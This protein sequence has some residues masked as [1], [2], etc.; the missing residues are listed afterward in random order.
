MVTEILADGEIALLADGG[1]L[2]RAPRARGHAG[3]D[4][5]LPCPTRRNGAGSAEDCDRLCRLP[6]GSGGWT[7]TAAKRSPLGARPRSDDALVQATGAL[8]QD[9]RRR[10]AT[11]NW[12]AWV[13]PEALRESRARRAPTTL[14]ASSPLSGPRVPVTRA[15]ASRVLDR[16]VKGGDR[17]RV[18]IADVA[19]LNTPFKRVPVRRSRGVDEPLRAG[20]QVLGTGALRPPNG[21]LAETTIRTGHGM[22]L[23]WRG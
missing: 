8:A 14:S 18:E 19:R 9:E 5:R 11:P 17:D 6:P 16:G 2:G 3:S 21:P 23:A 12:C 7:R 22:R 13:I 20:D 1:W 10:T 4:Q 15:S